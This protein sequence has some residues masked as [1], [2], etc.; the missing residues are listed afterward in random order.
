[1][2]C[3]QEV[4]NGNRQTPLE[5]VWNAFP[6]LNQTKFEDS[7]WVVLTSK[8]IEVRLGVLSEG[9]PRVQPLSCSGQADNH[10]D[11]DAKEE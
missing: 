2:G 1:M 3:G 7:G 4:E 6:T 11:V 9:R 5:A 8:H 10:L